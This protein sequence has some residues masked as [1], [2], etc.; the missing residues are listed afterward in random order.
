MRSLLDLL[1]EYVQLK[2]RSTRRLALAGRNPLAA[3]LLAALDAE[4]GEQQ[5]AVE[6][7]AQA[8]QAAQAAQQQA[9]VA[10]QQAQAQWLR[11]QQAG[12]Q[13]PQAAMPHHFV[14]LGQHAHFAAQ[15]GG[16]LYASSAAAAGRQGAVT[17][18]RQRKGAPRKRQR[19]AASPAG[20]G[21]GA[22]AGFGLLGEVGEAG[23]S[24]SGWGSPTDL[25][26]LQ[27]D[28]E[29]LEALLDDGP[30][31]VGRPAV[32]ALDRLRCRGC[33]LWRAGS[34]GWGLCRSCPAEADFLHQ[35]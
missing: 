24:G 25:L 6:A 19:G 22:G 26:N 9:A 2:E 12:A 17:P 20:G 35:A 32:C 1:N 10:A 4:A 11:E 3:R 5:G 23:G 29:G 15:A 7:A 27:L 16:Q 30:L 13:P 28:A 33:G 14:P 8:E 18:G 31:Q 34:T 21:G